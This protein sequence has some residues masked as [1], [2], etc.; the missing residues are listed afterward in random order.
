MAILTTMKGLP[1]AYNKDM[2]EDKEALFDTVDTVEICL[3][4][5]T[6]LLSDV[7]FNGDAMREAA[8][9]GFLTATDLADYLAAKGIPFRE[10]HEIVGRLVLFAMEKGKELNQLTLKQMK[11]Y[12]RQIEE[13]VFDWLDPVRCVERRNLPGGTGPEAVREALD[14]ARKE[15]A[16]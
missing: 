13:D 2:Q 4:V 15:L 7:T 5:L 8:D 11:T 12:S 10:A 6:R 9:K 14:Q 1:L 3:M 16:S